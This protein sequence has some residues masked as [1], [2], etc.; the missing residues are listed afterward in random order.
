MYE[1]S[2]LKKYK[3]L[4]GFIRKCEQE[5]IKAGLEEYLESNVCIDKNYP[6]VR[7]NITIKEYILKGNSYY[8]NYS[9]E[10]G[11][12]AIDFVFDKDFSS[13]IYV[14]SEWK[15]EEEKY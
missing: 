1:F 14:F 15:K 7:E 6:N 4:S 3:T 10:N 8:E 11:R 9:D 12:Y 2:Q 5:L 13:F